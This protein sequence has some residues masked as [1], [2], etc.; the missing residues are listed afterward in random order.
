MKYIAFVIFQPQGTVTVGLPPILKEKDV[1]CTD[2]GHVHDI[3]LCPICGDYI[4]IG[5][6][7]MG[8][9]LGVYKFCNTDGCAWF[10][11]TLDP[12]EGMSETVN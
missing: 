10:F 6:G 2:C 9:G 4:T 5:Y 8:G 7:L 1:L 3:E 11:K 12:F